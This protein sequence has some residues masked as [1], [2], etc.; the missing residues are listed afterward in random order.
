VDQ[1]VPSQRKA[2]AIPRPDGEIARPPARHRVGDGQLTVSRIEY[3][4]VNAV[5][6]FALCHWPFC[7]IHKPARVEPSDVFCC[8]PTTAHVLKFGQ[9]TL[10]KSAFAMGV[11]AM[12][13]QPCPFQSKAA[14]SYPPAEVATEP[15]A[16]QRVPPLQE[17][18]L[19]FMLALVAAGRVTLVHE[20]PLKCASSPW[21][22]LVTFVVLPLAPPPTQQSL[23]VEHAA[24]F[25]P[26]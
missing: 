5:G 3:G 13:R 19:K 15:T 26:P 21:A 18:P 8:T 25:K 20:R 2:L 16:A 9:P 12:S 14:P 6:N 17:T 24:A 11:A 7:H 22:D 4:R 1:E 23:M 10:R